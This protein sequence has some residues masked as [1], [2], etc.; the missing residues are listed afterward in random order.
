[1]GTDV[2]AEVDALA[3][4]R[5]TSEQRL[6]ELVRLPDE[7]EHGAVMVDVH[8]HVEESRRGRESVPERL[9][10]PFVASLGEVR[11]RLEHGP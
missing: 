6:D 7:R 10:D 8:V 2:A 3:R 1:V 4:A 9:D 5:D 11:H